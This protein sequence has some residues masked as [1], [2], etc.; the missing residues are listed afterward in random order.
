MVDSYRCRPS[1][2]DLTPD[3]RRDALA[4]LFAEGFLYLVDN[5]LL[6]EVLAEGEAGEGHAAGNRENAV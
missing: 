3:E 4:D 2:E 5:G 6:A 1:P